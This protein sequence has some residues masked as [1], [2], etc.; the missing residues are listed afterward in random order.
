ML[1]SRVRRAIDWVSGLAL[2]AFGAR[3]AAEG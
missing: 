2:V 1:R 3:L